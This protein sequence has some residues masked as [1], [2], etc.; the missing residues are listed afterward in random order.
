MPII[1]SS[2]NVLLKSKPKAK[3]RANKSFASPPPSILKVNNNSQ[4]HITNTTEKN[5]LGI[6]IILKHIL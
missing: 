1:Y 5:S 4:T 6:D 2:I 3:L